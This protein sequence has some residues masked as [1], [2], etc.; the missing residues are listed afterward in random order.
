VIQFDQLQQQV[1]GVVQTNPPENL[2][3]GDCIGAVLAEPILAT[4]DL[5]PFDNSAMDGYAVRAAD[6]ANLP[7]TLRVV[8]VSSAGHPADCTVGTAEAARILTGA[9]MVQGADTVVRVEDTEPAE[10]AQTPGAQS[11][12]VIITAAPAPGANIRR[13]GEAARTGDEL[14]AAGTLLNPG[15]LGLAASAGRS[16]LMVIERPRVA[17]LSTGDELLPPGAGQLGPGQIFESNSTVLAALARSMGCE[18]TTHHCMDD[19]AS[20]RTLLMELAGSHQLILSSGG[21]SMGGEYDSMRQAVAGFDVEFLKIAIRPAKPIA[22]GK[23][24][25]SILFGLPGNPVSSVVAFEL[26]VRPAIRQISG[27]APALPQMLHGVA[28]EQLPRLAGEF[29]YMLSTRQD[30][31]GDWVSTG[32]FGSHVLGG[33]AHAQALA[34]IPPGPEPV[35]KGSDLHLIPLWS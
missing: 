24:Q 29:T 4:V 1:L 22:F 6:I 7:A 13:A 31:Q 14:V 25:D 30:S 21:V 15:H 23:I 16:E 35:A 27:L 10:N 9:V 8:G 3:L 5:P 12:F 11:E 34:V 17:V 20:L 2:V 18:V 28:G 19:A 32:G 33:I 26:F